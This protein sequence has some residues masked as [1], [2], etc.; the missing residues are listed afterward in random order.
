[1]L[2]SIFFFLSSCHQQTDSA[3]TC[4]THSAGYVDK[5]DSARLIG[6]KE[7]RRGIE[8]QVSTGACK[9]QIIPY[10]QEC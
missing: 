10:A 2:H 3:G 4:T 6:D 8:R 5:T 1:M 7:A 9:C